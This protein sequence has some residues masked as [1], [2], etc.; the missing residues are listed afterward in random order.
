[1]LGLMH[2]SILLIVITIII[3]INIYH[4]IPLPPILC[5][6][7]GE[8]TDR[9]DQVLKEF[10]LWP[11]QIQFVEAI[12]K[13]PGWKGCTLSHLKCIEIAKERN[14]PW[15]L[16]IEDDCQLRP[17]ALKSFRKVLPYLWQYRDKWDV[18]SGGI[19]LLKRPGAPI[20]TNLSL[21]EANGYAAQFILIHA[22]TYDK[23]L[24]NMPKDDENIKIIDV[25]YCEKMRMWTHVPYLSG[26]R[27]D[28]SD[29]ENKDVNYIKHFQKSENTLLKLLE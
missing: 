20:N 28:K 15:V 26:Q 13:K 14:Y 9:R 21:I 5:I 6:N 11:A 7:L 29:I 23:I 18:F 16:C 10:A 22:G 8:R 3:A 1:M 19:S 2:Y 4:R 25:F 24:N 17:G 12:R 27:P